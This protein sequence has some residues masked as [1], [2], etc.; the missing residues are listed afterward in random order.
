MKLFIF[1]TAQ[2]TFGPYQAVTEEGARKLWA[3]EINCEIDELPKC[4]V[5]YG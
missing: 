4:E 3:K 5:Y 2:G 1:I